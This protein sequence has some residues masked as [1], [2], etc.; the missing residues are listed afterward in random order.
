MSN[1]PWFN[2]KG[3]FPKLRNIRMLKWIWD[4]R[5]TNSQWE[6]VEDTSFTNTL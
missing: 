3:D 4:L 6:G 2:K 5:P 1:F